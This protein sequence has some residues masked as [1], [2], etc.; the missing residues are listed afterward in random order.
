[1]IDVR[2]VIFVINSFTC[3]HLISSKDVIHVRGIQMVVFQLINSSH[4]KTHFK[5]ED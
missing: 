4:L 5:L 3:V 1:M 2:Y